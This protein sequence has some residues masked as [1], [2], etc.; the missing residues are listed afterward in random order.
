[1][2]I[3]SIPK[4]GAHAKT[5]FGLR[6]NV[7]MV[8]AGA[9][10]RLKCK[11]RVR[12]MRRRV[13]SRWQKGIVLSIVVGTFV[14]LAAW[15]GYRGKWKPWGNPIPFTEALPAFLMTAMIIFV[16]YVFRS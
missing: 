5:P 10:V 1:M 11:A 8:P 16:S 2:A 7:D 4:L 6:C 13:E 9:V 3:R 15:A 12:L 14:M